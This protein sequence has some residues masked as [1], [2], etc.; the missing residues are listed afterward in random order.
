MIGSI[1]VEDENYMLLWA[2]YSPHK[3]PQIID[4]DQAFGNLMTLKVG[5]IDPNEL[6]T[7]QVGVALFNQA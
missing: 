4:I 1:L 7:M 2:L 6:A 3:R 5:V